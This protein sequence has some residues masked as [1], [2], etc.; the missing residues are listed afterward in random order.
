M[1]FPD[2]EVPLFRLDYSDEQVWSKVVHTALGPESDR[3]D[4]LTIVEGPEFA[5]MDI[6]ELLARL[7]EDDPGYRF[8]VVADERTLED[9]DHL[10]TVITATNPPGSLPVAARTLPDVI[11]NLWISNLDFADYTAAADP[12]GVYRA[13]PRHGTE[14]QERA[15]QVDEIIEAMGDGPR[16]GPLEEFRI[17]LLNY[18]AQAASR[19]F[20]P[21]IDARIAYEN[22]SRRPISDYSK[23]WDVYGHDEYLDALRE[24]GQVLAFRLDLMTGHR[25]NHWSAVLDLST[26]RVLGAVRWIKHSS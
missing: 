22:S 20:M 10:F 17:A 6:Y 19:V 5:G 7:N 18:R 26:L 12:D 16:S 11:A 15:V 4:P 24:G 14:P 1:T 25:D 2:V 13:A 8:I 23:Y 9:P 3:T 21:L